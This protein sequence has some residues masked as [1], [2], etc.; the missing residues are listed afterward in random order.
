MAILCTTSHS[1]SVI[2]HENQSKL[3]L[4]R[5][6]HRHPEHLG[7]VSHQIFSS[8]PFGFQK[9]KKAIPQQKKDPD[10]IICP[11]PSLFSLQVTYIIIEDLRLP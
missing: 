11:D 2:I 6:L 5:Y 9:F 8:C 1:T 4:F 10:N 7:Q 3:N